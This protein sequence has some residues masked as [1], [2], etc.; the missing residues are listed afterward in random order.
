MNRV[1]GSCSCGLEV[2]LAG[3]REP[4]YRLHAG[5]GGAESQAVRGEAGRSGAGRGGVSPD[6]G[7]PPQWAS[8]ARVSLFK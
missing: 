5:L 7:A 3:S 4:V 6:S 2:V 8:T 1:K